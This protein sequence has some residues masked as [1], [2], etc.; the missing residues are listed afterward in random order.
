MI[1]QGSRVLPE[2]GLQARAHAQL[3]GLVKSA[4]Y[5]RKVGHH[6]SLDG[7]LGEITSASRGLPGEKWSIADSEVEFKR[8]SR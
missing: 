2:R 3:G 8:K 1:G 5:V 6:G 7:L 4:I